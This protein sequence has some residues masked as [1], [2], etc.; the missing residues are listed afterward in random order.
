MKKNFKMME[1]CM[2]RMKK[3]MKENDKDMMKNMKQHIQKNCGRTKVNNTDRVIQTNE[4][5]EY[6]T[7]ELRTLFEDWLIQL[8]DEIIKLA[9]DKESITPEDVSNEFKISKQ[10]AIFVLGKLAQKNKVYI[11]G[12]STDKE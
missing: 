11:D 6:A 9:K 12:I 1:K 8:E 3:H 2:D 7:P 10:S 5:A 4:I